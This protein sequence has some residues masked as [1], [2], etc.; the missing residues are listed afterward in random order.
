MT[1]IGKMRRWSVFG[2]TKRHRYVLG[3]EWDSAKS[4]VMFI[5]LNP[6]IADSEIDDPTCR[7]G[8]GFARRLGFGSMI[9]CNLFAFVSTNPDV[10]KSKWL[11]S[12]LLGCTSEWL[13]L[14]GPKNSEH[15]QQE[16]KDADTIIVA[17]GAR[18][19]WRRDEEV[20][21]LLAERELKCLGKTRYGAPR[22]ILYLPYAANLVP[23]SAG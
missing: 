20:V 3:R 9:F 1:D 23:Y 2:K 16:A 19:N 13:D 18:S 5:L 12:K 21:C 8:I 11:E 4:R 17:W 7:R 15:I 22:H 6:S 10:L 14:V